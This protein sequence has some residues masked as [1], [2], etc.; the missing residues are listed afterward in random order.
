MFEWLAKFNK[1]IV[2][3]PHR[4]GTR[5][6]AKMIAHDT[7][8][9]YV[10]ESDIYFDC[11]HALCRLLGNTKR[12]VIQCPAL[13]RYVHTLSTDDLS[14]VMMRR[15]EEDIIA[16]QKRLNQFAEK[17][18]LA[19]YDHSSGV[20]ARIK[21]Q[22]WEQEQRDRIKHAFEI[23]YESLATHPLWIP[24]PLRQGFS[25]VQTTREEDLVVNLSDRPYIAPTVLYWKSPNYD[26]ALLVQPVGTTQIKQINSTGWRIWSMCDGDRTCREI[27][28]ILISEFEGAE[29]ESLAHDLK[30][31]IK[32][33]VLRGFLRL[34]VRPKSADE[35]PG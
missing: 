34:A 26:Y 30:M 11:L 10:D 24:K 7:G 29:E 16:S 25:F 19:R 27:L 22:F 18:E 31:F 5:I 14:V 4:A 33:L 20:L 2:T 13:C 3:G 8:Y 32:D 9:E 6:C 35:S 15:D 21:Y 1:I 12:Y 28:E 17:S 23:E